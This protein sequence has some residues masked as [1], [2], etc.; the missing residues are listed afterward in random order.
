MKSYHRH[1]TYVQARTFILISSQRTLIGNSWNHMP[2]L[3]QTST[4]NGLR[5]IFETCYIQFIKYV[6]RKQLGNRSPPCS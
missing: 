1:H 4:E 5:K 3:K 6:K 2:I